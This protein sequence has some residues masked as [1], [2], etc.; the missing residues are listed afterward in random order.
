MLKSH[1]TIVCTKDGTVY[2]N[3]LGNPG[4][5]TGG[6]GDVLAGCIASFLSQGHSMEDAA[7][8]GVYIHSLSAD[9]AAL[10]KGEYSLTPSDIIE[11][12]PYA[13]KHSKEL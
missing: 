4:M 6:S 7:K 9:M 2:E 10:D 1:K 5:A 12:L 11:F 8:L 13:I 3:P